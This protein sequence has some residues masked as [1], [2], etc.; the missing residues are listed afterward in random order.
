MQNSKHTRPPN[1]KGL[2][3]N[4]LASL[5]QLRSAAQ[6]ATTKTVVASTPLP[7]RKRVAQAQQLAAN[8]AQA[9]LAVAPLTPVV[10]HTADH[11]PSASTLPA[12]DIKLF[13]QAMTSVT[14]IKGQQ[15]VLVEPVPSASAQLLIE[16]RQ[17]ASGDTNAPLAVQVSD[18]YM[19]AHTD[20][21]DRVFI[22][23][24]HAGDLIKGLRRGKWP[25]QASLDLHGSTLDQ[26]RERLDRFLFSCLEHQIR[27]VR[28]VHG[29]GYG[30]RN[31]TPI[32]K[33]VVRRWLTQLAAVQAYIEC[34][35]ADGGAGAVQILLQQTETKENI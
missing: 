34:K 21:N 15:R 23:S 30:S 6:L 14:P 18:H 12:V 5:K 1:G 25:V 17:H 2:R 28:V 10:G 26:A 22:R 33:D 8:L 31:N 29:K 19:A 20:Q 7:K 27:C 3:S 16:R 35:E 11:A 9:K 4:D 32:L 24:P 13:R